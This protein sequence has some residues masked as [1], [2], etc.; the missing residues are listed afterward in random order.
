MYGAGLK[1]IDAAGKNATSNRTL[2]TY[3]NWWA[4]WILGTVNNL[5]FV[6]VMGAAS[7][8]ACKFNALDDIAAISWANVAV[9]VFVRLANTIF[10]L[11]ISETRRIAGASVCFLVGLG[12]VATSALS[13]HSTSEGVH[14]LF[15]IAILSI[16]VL[17]AAC[18]FAE[19]VFLGFLRK[20]P[21][22][23]TNGWSSGTGMAGVGGAFLYLGLHSAG[24]SDGHV[25]LTSFPLSS[26]TGSRSVHADK[27]SAGR[28]GL[29]TRT[30]RMRSAPQS[31][32]GVRGRPTMK[33]GAT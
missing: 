4:F 7:S 3:R 32:L 21:V 20:Y 18:S 27:A 19:S 28:Y 25:F 29:M 30:M 24:V 13:D 2:N 5:A 1:A 22:T 12:G 6:V 31:T 11:G 16:V 8:L 10:L 9:G 26:S 17:G 14:P 33:R 15:W 23:M